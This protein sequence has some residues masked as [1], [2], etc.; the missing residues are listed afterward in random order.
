MSILKNSRV[1]A[2]A[3]RINTEHLLSVGFINPLPA[4]RTVHRLYLGT[5][6]TNSKYISRKDKLTN[7]GF[8]ENWQW[9]GLDIDNIIK[10]QLLKKMWEAKQDKTRRGFENKLREECGLNHKTH[11]GSH[12]VRDHNV[13]VGGMV[14]FEP[15]KF[16]KATN[17]YKKIKPKKW[18]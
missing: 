13:G 8:I 3:V 1:G 15:K 9:N 10:V 6:N 11:I 18:K 16:N 7:E 4:D 14:V 5:H 17:T 2:R 12:E